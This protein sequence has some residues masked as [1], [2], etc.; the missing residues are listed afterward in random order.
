M[1]AAD[2]T[3]LDGTKDQ[4]L[5]MGVKTAEIFFDAVTTPTAAADP[6][7]PSTGASMLSMGVATLAVAMTLF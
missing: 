1:A 2:T 4:N 6:K 7:T 5:K 3:A